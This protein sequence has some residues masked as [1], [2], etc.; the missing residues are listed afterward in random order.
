ML[1]IAVRSS[2]LLSVQE[3]MGALS[4][5][6]RES[7]DECMACLSSQ[8]RQ[9]ASSET[10][11]RRLREYG[12]GLLEVL[13]FNES[14]VVQLMHQTVKDFISTPGFIHRVLGADVNMVFENGHSF[15][16]K[17]F[18]AQAVATGRDRNLQAILGPIQS[19]A[20]EI[21]LLG[22]YHAQLSESTT[23]VSQGNFF[24]SLTDHAIRQA[25]QTFSGPQI[26]VECLWRLLP[27]CASMFAN[28]WQN[29]KLSIVLR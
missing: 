14:C 15:L 5:A 2:R 24:N 20:T 21:A 17:Y 16:A 11:R 7:F 25:Y 18:I 22:M 1:E 19:Y 6:S 3:F 10:V 12:G 13:H 9:P 8:W 26:I 4:C 27:I 29:S 28:L 23:G